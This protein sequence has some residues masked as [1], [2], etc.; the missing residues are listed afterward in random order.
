LRVLIVLL[1]CVFLPITSN[2]EVKSVL[3]KIDLQKG[4]EKL[5][6]QCPSKL[7]PVVETNYQDY[8]EYCSD[9]LNICLDQCM[10][11]KASYCVGLANN[12]ISDEIQY[13]YS[14]FVFAKACQKGVVTACTNRAAGI[15][16]FS[17]ERMECVANSFAKTCEY[18]DAWGCTMY[19]LV[20]SRG[21]GIDANPE[22]ALKVL[23]AGCKHGSDDSA[24][25]S[26]KAIENQILNNE[27]NH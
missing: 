18:D 19:G 23:K 4:I 22:L 25:K 20:L 12:V 8:I 21:M 7:M 1:L 24:C 14:E 11:G 2:A 3:S 26:A 16:R 27:S 10:N 9:K 17:A 15:M 6:D 13:K 5:L